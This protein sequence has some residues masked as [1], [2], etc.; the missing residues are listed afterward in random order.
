[1]NS[2]RSVA[3]LFVS[4]FSFLLLKISVLMCCLTHRSRQVYFQAVVRSYNERFGK[5]SDGLYERGKPPSW[6][7]IF[8]LF[9]CQRPVLEEGGGAAI[10][11]YNLLHTITCKEKRSLK[12]RKPGSAPMLNPVSIIGLFLKAFLLHS[13]QLRFH[14]NTQ[15]QAGWPGAV[16]GSIMF[17]LHFSPETDNKLTSWRCT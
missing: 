14:Q 5:D 4:V 16:L 13:L 2:S 3:F 17:L 8:I 9:F 1:M 15:G 7:T 12:M 11:L 10:W 6:K